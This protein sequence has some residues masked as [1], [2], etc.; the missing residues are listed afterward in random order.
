MPNKHSLRVATPLLSLYSS[1]VITNITAPHPVETWSFS[2]SMAKRRNRH[3]VA[4]SL[5]WAQW[6]IFTT[7][8]ITAVNS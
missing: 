8:S 3:L 1:Y 2:Y 4:I 5:Y 7:L 6:C